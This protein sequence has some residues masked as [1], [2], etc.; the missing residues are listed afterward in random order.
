MS[1]SYIAE[2]ENRSVIAQ[3]QGFGENMEQFLVDL[4]VVG[5]FDCAADD[6]I[7]LNILKT[8]ILW[9]DFLV[10]E[11]YLNKAMFLKS[12]QTNKQLSMTKGEAQQQSTRLAEL[13]SKVQP[14]RWTG[15]RCSE[16]R[17][18]SL[19]LCHLKFLAD[20]CVCHE[21]ISSHCW[22]VFSGMFWGIINKAT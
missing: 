18:L 21:L 10:W 3:S 8:L 15:P 5:N 9:V 11:V 6:Y 2:A 4:R 17:M 12:K 16:L 1:E 20:M 22:V 13:Q 19:G 7:T 14:N